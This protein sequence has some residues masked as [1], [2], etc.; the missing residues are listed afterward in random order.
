MLKLFNYTVK[1]FVSCPVF[2]VCTQPAQHSTEPLVSWTGQPPKSNGNL[3]YRSL[4]AIVKSQPAPVDQV[5]G[6][7]LSIQ[8][9]PAL[10][11]PTSTGRR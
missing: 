6:R 4:T 7:R 10:R 2:K 3:R 5:T 9:A 8:P 1:Q 11:S